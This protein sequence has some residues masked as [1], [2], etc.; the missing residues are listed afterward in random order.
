VHLADGRAWV[1]D[2]VQLVRRH[3]IHEEVTASREVRYRSGTVQYSSQP[4][5]VNCGKRTLACK[6]VNRIPPVKLSH[7]GLTVRIIRTRLDVLRGV[8]QSPRVSPGQSVS[9]VAVPPRSPHRHKGRLRSPRSTQV[10]ST[11]SLGLLNFASE[12]AVSPSRRC[13][14][15]QFLNLM[16]WRWDG[17]RREFR[18][19][20]IKICQRLRWRQAPKFA[21][22]LHRAY[23]IAFYSK[24]DSCVR[25]DGTL[26]VCG[27]RALSFEDVIGHT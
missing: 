7:V 11:R 12:V 20:Q 14:Y 10:L 13:F 16:G 18:E 6:V 23:W 27:A 3:V 8:S 24:F 17:S 25:F 21:H 9:F 15:L 22:G 19:F 5:F 4:P 26:R 2:R 1:G